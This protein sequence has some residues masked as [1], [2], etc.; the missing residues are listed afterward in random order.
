MMHKSVTAWLGATSGMALMLGFA[1]PAAA[2][3]APNPETSVPRSAG[4]EADVPGDIIVTAQKREERLKDVPSS[5]AV[6]GGAN[7][8]QQSADTLEDYVAR[9]PGLS[10]N[11]RSVGQQQ[12]NIRGV[13]TGAGQNSTV[14]IYIDDAPVG[15][16]NGDGVGGLV[17]PEIDSIDLARIEV[18]RGPQGTL[19]GASNIGGLV[20]YVTVAPNLT[21]VE[22]AGSLEGVSASHGEQGYAVRGRVSVPIVEDKIA[23][24]ASG[25]VR[26]DPGFVDDDGLRREDLDD[27]RAEGWRAALLLK[28][29]DELSISLAALGSNKHSDGFTQVDV[30]S[31]TLAPLFGPYEQRRG[32]GAEYQT[33]RVRLYSANVAYDL[34]FA[35]LSSTTSYNK[36]YNRA[37]QDY[38][39]FFPAGTFDFLNPTGALDFSNLGTSVPDLITQNKLTEEV[40]LAGRIGDAFDYIVGGY[41]T[42]ERSDTAVNFTSFNTVTGAPINVGALLLDSRI[43]TQYRELAGFAQATYHFGPRFDLTAGIRYAHNTERATTVSDGVFAGGPS[44]VRTAAKGNATTFSVAPSFKI[45]PDVTLYARV[46]TGYRPGGPNTVVAPRVIYDPDRVTNYEA[47]VKGALDGGRLTFDIDVFHVDWTGIQL[48]VVDPNTGLQYVANVGKASSRGVEGSI[49]YRVTRQLNVGVSAAYVD[50]K[51]DQDFPSNALYGLRDSPL[52]YAPKYKLAATAD[53]NRDLGHDLSGFIGT[54]VYYS[55]A[56]S[57]EFRNS[58]TASRTRLPGYATVDGRL[59]VSRG[60][61]SLSFIAKNLFD[62]RGFNGSTQLSGADNGPVTLNIIQPRT[63]AL[64][65]RFNY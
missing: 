53:Y 39:R 33:T 12:L 41:Y 61:V 5:I 52:P 40:R 62:K 49:G 21:R 30:D 17:T 60:P 4:A 2:Q 47:G 10:L 15:A 44:T 28:P 46:A 11:A 8:Q 22:A 32:R 14:A 25:Y 7:L 3:T 38:T 45:T 57:G 55:S 54:G 42:R 65:L 24:L 43:T 1:D 19:Y 51:L 31:V 56:V 26:R 16:S 50:A 59:G 9:V 13:S 29:T 37:A 35:Q 23:F 34:G 27:L 6:L 48:Q 20:K 36:V 58:A 63:L 18:L 64:N